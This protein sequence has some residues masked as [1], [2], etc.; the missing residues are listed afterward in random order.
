E[1]SADPDFCYSD[2]AMLVYTHHIDSTFSMWE[3]N[4][5]QFS[6]FEYDTIQMIL[7]SPFENVKLTVNEFGCISEPVEMQL[8]RKPNFDF[9]TE[10]LEGCQP[11][12]FEVFAETDDNLI[13]FTWLADS[14]PYP[15]GS[16]NLVFLSD[17]GKFDMS[18]IAHSNE[19]GC[20][21]TLLKPDWIRVHRNPYAK[22]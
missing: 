8:K 16:S 3:F 13:D 4:D 15:T 20:T 19:T 14:L 18:L 6:G 21:D 12:N 22:F 11:F 5:T 7:D 10:S 9:Y 17:T 1:I 2:S